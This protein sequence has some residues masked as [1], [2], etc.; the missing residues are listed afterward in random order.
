MGAFGGGRA[1]RAE[2]DDAEDLDEAGDGERAGGGEQRGGERG[3]GGAG[4][5]GGAGQAEV[6]DELADEAVERRQAADGDGAD[7][8]EGGGRGHAAGETA[9]LLEVAGAGRVDHRAG[10]EEEQRLEE[11]VVPDVEQAAGQA[12]QD[13]VGAAGGAPGERQPQTEQDDPDVLDRCG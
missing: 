11:R 9:H 12:E 13:P 4:G 7:E 2:E 5:D 8:E 6:D 3:P 10:A 1:R